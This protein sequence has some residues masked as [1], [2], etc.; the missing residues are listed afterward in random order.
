MGHQHREHL[1]SMAYRHLPLYYQKTTWI[2]RTY[3]R[4]RP[5]H[6]QPHITHR[7]STQRHNPPHL[8]ALH[9]S[10]HQYLDAQLAPQRDYSER[11]HPSPSTP[12]KPPQHHPQTAKNTTPSRSLPSRLSHLPATPPTT[13]PPPLRTSP[14]QTTSRNCSGS[15]SNSKAARRRPPAGRTRTQEKGRGARRR[16]L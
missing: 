12:L 13:S 2:L 14:P 11:G 16:R 4:P 8:W 15:G 6:Q 1:P 9:P 3:L 10:P 7:P 5:R